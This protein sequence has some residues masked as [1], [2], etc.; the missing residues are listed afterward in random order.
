MFAAI[1]LP[2]LAVAAALRE[3]S[4]QRDQPCAVLAPGHQQSAAKLPLLA[5]NR[6]ARQTGLSVGWPLNRALVRCPNLKILDRAPHQEALL[7]QEVLV[8]AESLTPDFERSSADTVILDLTRCRTSSNL[9]IEDFWLE[10]VTVVF[11]LGESPDLA[12]VLACQRAVDG[13][14]AIERFPLKAI[15]PISKD[16]SSLPLLKLWG[17]K[18]LGDLME[19]PRQALCE[20]LGSEVGRWHDVLHGKQCRKLR[21][22]QPP[23]TWQQSIEFEDP[24]VSTDQVLFAL[25]RLL[26][27]LAEQLALRHLAVKSLQLGFFIESQESLTRILRFPEPLASAEQLFPPLQAMVGSLQLT[28]PLLRLSLDAEST[29]A[30]QGQ[31]QWFEQRIAQPARWA[32]TLAK[33]EAMVGEGRMGIPQPQDSHAPDG[34]VMRSARGAER[35]LA[36]CRETPA[37]SVPLHRF[38]PSREVSVAHEMSGAWPRPLAILNGMHVGEITALR[39]PFPS[40]GAWWQADVAWSRLEWDI[41]LSGRELLRLAFESPHQWQLEGIYL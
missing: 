18:T 15:L 10:G 29:L 25:K 23:E 3:R 24:L 21:C 1:H 2:D 5:L 19:L 31:R 20:R 12:H 6:P 7:L 8:F 37:C 39:G 30:S 33:L 40:S 11:A 14:E 9:A 13:G 36:A 22:N 26:H 35:P 27:R 17:V 41:Q 38:R 28:G 32:E 4:D 16:A 34:F